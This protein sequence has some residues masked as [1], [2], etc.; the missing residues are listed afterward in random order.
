MAGGILLVTITI[1]GCAALYFV[2]GRYDSLRGCGSA[3]KLMS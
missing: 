1:I 3:V 2:A